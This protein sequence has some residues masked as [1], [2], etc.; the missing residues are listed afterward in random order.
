MILRLELVM[1]HRIFIGDPA[2]TIS[3]DGVSEKNIE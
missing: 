3:V 1:K 2:I